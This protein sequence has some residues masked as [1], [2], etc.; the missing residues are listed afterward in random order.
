MFSITS[1][2]LRVLD[3]AVASRGSPCFLPARTIS[4]CKL[5]RLSRNIAQAWSPYQM[6]WP[7]LPNT[8]V[9]PIQITRPP[10]RLCAITNGPECSTSS[11]SG[12]FE[13]GDMRTTK[14]C[15]TRSYLNVHV[16]GKALDRHPYGHGDLPRKEEERRFTPRPSLVRCGVS[17]GSTILA[18]SCRRRCLQYGVPDVALLCIDG[19]LLQFWSLEEEE[20]LLLC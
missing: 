12:A 11:W 13:L 2:S 6:L 20:M 15:L 18:T 14:S 9:K 3:A 8:R 7:I 10:F 5:Q 19:G 4:A 1:C 16:A 17:P